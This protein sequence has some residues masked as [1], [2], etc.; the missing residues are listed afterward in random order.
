ML[1]SGLLRVWQQLV[2]AQ[3]HVQRA[4]ET[5]L[6]VT[7]LLLRGRAIFRGFSKNWWCSFRF[8]MF[9]SLSREVKSLALK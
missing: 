8:G 4:P 7:T 2:P 6:S 3:G 5:E 9:G 1:R